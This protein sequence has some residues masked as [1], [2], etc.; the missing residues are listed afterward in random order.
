[1]TTEYYRY[2]EPRWKPPTIV[3]VLIFFTMLSFLIL[4]LKGCI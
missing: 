4:K 3:D 1:M 2:K